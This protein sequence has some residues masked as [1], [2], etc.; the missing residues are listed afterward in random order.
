MLF[1]LTVAMGLVTGLYGVAICEH[2]KHSGLKPGSNPIGP[3]VVVVENG[4][5]NAYRH[6]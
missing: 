2:W 4:L 3:H 6:A 1:R 5:E